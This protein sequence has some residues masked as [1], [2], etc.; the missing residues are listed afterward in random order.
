MVW[1]CARYQ[2]TPDMECYSCLSHDKVAKHTT[3][4]RWPPQPCCRNQWET[5]I[6]SLQFQLLV[7]TIEHVSWGKLVSR[8]CRCTLEMERLAGKL[9]GIKVNLLNSKFVNLS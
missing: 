8:T 7:A 4:E 1:A 3:V 6:K 9:G 5:G 2:G